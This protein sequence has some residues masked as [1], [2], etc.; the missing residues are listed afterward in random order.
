MPKLHNKLCRINSADT[1]KSK[2]EIKENNSG[3]IIVLKK[4][5]KSV[6]DMEEKYPT[7][8]EIITSG[9]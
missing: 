1:T 5:T 9:R 3:L 2:K 4:R 8:T 6:N 7:A